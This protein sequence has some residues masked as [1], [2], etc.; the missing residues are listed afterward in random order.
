MQPKNWAGLQ[1]KTVDAGV[2]QDDHT[3]LQQKQTH[4]AATKKVAI[5]MYA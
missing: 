2:Y 1:D 5:K 4:R 3:D